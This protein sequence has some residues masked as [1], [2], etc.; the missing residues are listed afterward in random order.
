MNL[1]LSEDLAVIPLT[2]I[3]PKNPGLHGLGTVY[4]TVC[5]LDFRMDFI[6]EGA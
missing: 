1:S 6:M 2:S 3:E 5:G 4:V